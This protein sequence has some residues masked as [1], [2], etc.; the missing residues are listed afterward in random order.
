[1]TA[2]TGLGGELWELVRRCR[3]Q[4][5]DPE[6]ALRATARAF[7]DRLAQVEAELRRDGLDAAGLAPEQWAERWG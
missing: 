1:M 6:V 3:E 4:G 7:R 2:G 5:V